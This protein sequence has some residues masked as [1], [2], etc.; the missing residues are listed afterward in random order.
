[1]YKKCR[2]LQPYR[3]LWLQKDITLSYLVR[4]GVVVNALVVINEVTLR[5]A[6]LVLVWV[7][8]CGW[9]NHLGM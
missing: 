6:R 4:R 8:V 5:R 7:S 9:V 2:L 1:M 3:L